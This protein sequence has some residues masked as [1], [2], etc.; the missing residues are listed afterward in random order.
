MHVTDSTVRCSRLRARYYP[1]H[2]IWLGWN[3]LS[4]RRR[5]FPV[6]YN[7]LKS[8]CC[9][10]WATSLWSVHCCMRH[11]LS[12]KIHRASIIAWCCS[13][14]FTH[15]NKH[16]NFTVSLFFS[17]RWLQTTSSDTET[18]NASQSHKFGNLRQRNSNIW[19]EV[20]A[21]ATHPLNG[22]SNAAEDEW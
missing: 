11:W 17:W 20:Q 1:D 8:V 12:E 2:T 7:V 4:G 18:R 5:A 13:D 14:L 19:S 16:V 21:T 15:Q 6:I 3:N 22:R 9:G 10:R